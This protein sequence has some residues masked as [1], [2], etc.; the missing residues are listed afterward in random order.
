MLSWVGRA[1]TLLC[2]FLF[3]PFT[4]KDLQKLTLGPSSAI[5]PIM[6]Q[7]SWTVQSAIFNQ[8][9]HGG[10]ESPACREAA[11]FNTALQ[12]TPTAP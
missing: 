5:K 6:P 10:G 3:M 12:P 1:R 4:C 11:Q 8:E 9:S 2:L 7:A